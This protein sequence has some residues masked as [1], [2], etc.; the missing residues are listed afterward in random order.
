MQRELP[1]LFIAWLRDV[2]RHCWTLIEELQFACCR[3]V[4]QALSESYS[5]CGLAQCL[6]AVL[7][8]RLRH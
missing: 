8:N 4:E 1:A 7:H 6:T 5:I 2:K 3:D